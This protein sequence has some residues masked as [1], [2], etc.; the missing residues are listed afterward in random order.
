MS[1][2]VSI[3]GLR[4]TF[5]NVRAVDGV[6]LDVAK[7]ELVALLGPS[8]CG[9]TTLLRTIGGL[10]APDSGEIVV[11]G[12]IL[13]GP[14]RFVAPEKRGVV[15][16]F[17]DFALFPHMTVGANVAF[18]LARGS[19]RRERVAGL[20]EM[21][22]LGG[23]GKRYPHELSGGQQQRV[24]LARALAAKPRLMLLDEPFSNLD[25]AI[26]HRV[27]LE[28]RKLLRDIGMTAIFVT[29]DQDEALSL[30][31]RVAVMTNGRIEQVGAPAELYRHPATASVASFVGDSNLVDCRVQDGEAVSELGTF[32]VD[33]DFE[34]P[35]VL[36]VRPEDIAP[37]GHEMGVEA[38]VGELSYF[39]HDFLVTLALASG[40][41]VR[42][43]WQ[44][45]ELPR[46]GEGIRVAVTGVVQVFSNP[47]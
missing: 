43:R 31:D 16:V 21:V 34:G 13:N 35:G 10:E 11:D 6:D 8:G 1:S 45:V 3:R 9:K 30:A 24:A 7:G 18:G 46:R 40:R 33:A 39:G 25:P 44:G 32:R 47:A 20:L 28:V 19:G 15:V 22:D 23:L 38:V 4:K 5:G 12:E 27:R 26:R 37:A 17:Q 42:A 36:A 29:H 14:G 2:F 41:E